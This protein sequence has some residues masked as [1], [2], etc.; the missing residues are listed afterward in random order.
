ME[1][2]EEATRAKSRFL[3]NMS[4][5]LRT[6]LNAVIGI[7]EMLEED[8]E[9]LGQE[10]FIDP[11]RRIRGAGN[12]LLHLIN[13]ILDLSKIE[14]GRL[15]LHYEDLEVMP[16]IDDIAMT[17]APLA[18]K[19]GNRLE[20]HC[21]DDIGKMR[22]DMTRVRQVLLNLLSNACK[23]TDKGEVA[24]TVAS[25]GEGDDEDLTFTVKDTGIGM[26]PEQLARLFQE[27]SQ[28]D[29][30]TTRKYG[31]TGLGLAISRRLCRL[32]GG[33]VTVTS[34][35]DVGSTFTARLPR[36]DRAAVEVLGSPA[37]T[38]APGVMPQAVDPAT[39][40]QATG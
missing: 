4:H 39:Q 34:A 40:R 33:D 13:E 15:E 36:R 12:H 8:A 5:E 2:A 11:L 19:N 20:V 27:F 37:Q 30:S 1:Q 32:M 26:N 9:D 7:T 3:A 24:L 21:P 31:G 17:A 25:S 23:F 14:A 16:L 10:D 6:P 38:P 18:D 29:S 35:P 28:A 22:S